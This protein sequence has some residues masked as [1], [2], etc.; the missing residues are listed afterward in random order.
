MSKPIIPFT[1]V[2]LD[3]NQNL[4]LTLLDAYEQPVSR[5]GAKWP[6]RFIVTGTAFLTV[7]NS[8]MLTTEWVESVLPV[9]FE[10]KKLSESYPLDDLNLLLQK[11]PVIVNVDEF[12]IPHHYKYIYKK[13]HGLHSMLVTKKNENES[14]NIIDCVPLYHGEIDSLILDKAVHALPSDTL[15]YRVKYIKPAICSEAE[16]DME[17]LYRNFIHSILNE[18]VVESD[19]CS[20]EEIV[21]KIEESLEGYQYEKVIKCICD[22]YWIWQVDRNANLTM[23][24]M[25]ENLS[26]RWGGNT[27]EICYDMAIL[28]QKLSISFKKLYRASLAGSPA[29]FREVIKALRENVLQEKKLIEKIMRMENK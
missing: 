13:Q 11:Q 19:V 10:Y 5:L 3:C 1:K 2:V 25:Q 29:D 22:G 27:E 17:R 21:R 26:Q 15:R 18:E 28:N 9:V 12:H 24:Y 14:Y 16:Y 6:W 4:I 20:L 23:L 7:N 8:Y